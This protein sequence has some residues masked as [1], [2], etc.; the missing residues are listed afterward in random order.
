MRTFALLGAKKTRIFCNFWCGCT[1]KG[2]WT[3]VDILRT[4]GEG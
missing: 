1:D 2:G 3:S 4:K